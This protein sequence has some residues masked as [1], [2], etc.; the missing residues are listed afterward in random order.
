MVRAFPPQG[1]NNDIVV[2]SNF[3]PQSSEE[4]DD[5]SLFFESFSNVTDGKGK[6]LFDNVPQGTGNV[7][8]EEED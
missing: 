5:V 3:P 8:I 6:I 2:N 1:G 4:I 7:L